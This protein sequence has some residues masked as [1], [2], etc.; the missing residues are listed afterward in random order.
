M[1][2]YCISLILPTWF[3]NGWGLHIDNFVDQE[4][5][6]V[7][8]ENL[9]SH[10][11]W[12]D[13]VWLLAPS[14]LVLVKMVKSLTRVINE[15]GLLWKQTDLKILTTNLG[16]ADDFLIKTLDINFE[17]CHMKVEVVQELKVLGTL[18]SNDGSCIPTVNHRAHQAE[19]AFNSN[20][21]IL[22]CHEKSLNRRFAE[23]VKR[24]VLVFLHGCGGWSWCKNTFAKAEHL[25]HR[26]LAHIFEIRKIIWDGANGGSREPGWQWLPL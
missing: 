4:G 3:H 25:E 15:K 22:C 6:I 21:A 7:E 16:G 5:N 17:E 2:S 19:K 9:I 8:G 12:A 20:L 14:Q 11:I 24:V 26:L 1:I 23:Y 13:N 18:V 10:F